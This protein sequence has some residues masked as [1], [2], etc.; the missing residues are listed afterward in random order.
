[1][2]LLAEYV[3]SVL[4]NADHYKEAEAYYTGEVPEV[5]ASAKLRSA[6]ASTGYRGTQNYCRVVVDAVLH[7]LEI[8]NVVADTATA[9]TLVNK[10]WADNELALEANEIHRA[11]LEYG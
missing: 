3:R 2:T 7:R 11:A 9:Q 4:D 8:A 1:M 10:V 5:F 6:L